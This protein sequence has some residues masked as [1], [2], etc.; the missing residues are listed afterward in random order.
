MTHHVS[1]ARMSQEVDFGYFLAIFQNSAPFHL[2]S[3]AKS[4]KSINSNTN[5]MEVFSNKKKKV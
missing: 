4:V 2:K 1:T 5:L 3:N